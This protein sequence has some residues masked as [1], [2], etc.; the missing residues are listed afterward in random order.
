MFTIKKKNLITLVVSFFL[1]VL[2]LSS[3]PVLRTPFLS[4]FK[5]PLNILTFFRREAGAIIF[6]RR[7]F[8]QNKILNRQV[9]FLRSKLNSQNELIL[10]NSRLKQL[11]S[12]KQKSPLRLTAARVIGR[13]ADSWSASLIID[14]GRFNGIR[15]GMAA[16]TF[17]G[18]VGRIS[19]AQEFTSKVMLITDPNIGISAIDQR[20]RQEGLVSGTLGSNLIMRYLPEEPD[21]KIND[22]VI[23][24][25]L[26]SAYPK[27]SFIGT[28]VAIGK[29]FS[30]LSSYAIIKPAVNLSDIEEVLII[31]P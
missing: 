25:G 19:E 26:N 17:L 29:E 22:T 1:L 23:T 11:L 14:K 13:S 6:Y 12:F 10:E 21:I 24:S 16:V 28:V 3:I 5:F 30:G 2:L 4:T 20:S 8:T 31:I 18:L 9:D 27:G 7:N 15:Q